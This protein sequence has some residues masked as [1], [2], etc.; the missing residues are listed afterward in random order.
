MKTHAN[1]ETAVTEAKKALRDAQQ[2]H[3][4]LAREES[5]VA[6]D[7]TAASREA[8]RQRAE[9]ARRGESAATVSADMDLEAYRERQRQLPLERWAAELAVEESK[10]AL[11]DAEDRLSVARVEEANDRFRRLQPRFEDLKARYEKARAESSRDPVPYHRTILRKDAKSRLQHLEE[12][13]PG[14]W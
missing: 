13:Y 12:H 14:S 5:Q 6:Q 8:A 2:R 11:Y 7:L 1:L 9:A 4:S 10:L 3:Q